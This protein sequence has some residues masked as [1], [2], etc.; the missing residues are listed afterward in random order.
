MASK[1]RNFKKIDS[2]SFK[3]DLEF[4]LNNAGIDPNLMANDLVVT[5]QNISTKVLNFHAPV[6]ISS[7]VMHPKP[8]W[9]NENIRAQKQEQLRLERKWRKS[10]LPADKDAYWKQHVLFDKLLFDPKK[11]SI[12]RTA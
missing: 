4:E 11:N 2:A 5:L 10:R 1:V 9:Y 3:C 6:T 7:H 12:V 8:V